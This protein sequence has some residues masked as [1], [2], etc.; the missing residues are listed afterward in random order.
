VSFLGGDPD[1]P[2]ITGR[3]YTNLQ[4][5]PYPLPENKTRSGWKT[6]SSPTNGG[7]NEIMFEDK[8]GNELIQMRAQKNLTKQV[9]NDEMSSVGHNRSATIQKHD[10]KS[11]G[12]NQDHTVQGSNSSMTGADFTQQVMG[13]FASFASQDRV[14]NTSGTASSQ[15]QEHKLTADKAITLCVGNSVIYMDAGCIVFQSPQILLNPGEA[16][17]TAAALGASKKPS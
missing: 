7:Y 16:M 6:N 10:T 1:R 14:Q 12:G 5:T 2:V 17:T 13:M 9:N 11:V 15:A 8:A 4:K 3:V